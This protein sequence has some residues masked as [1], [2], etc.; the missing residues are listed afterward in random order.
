MKFSRWKLYSVFKKEFNV[1][2][3]ALDMYLPIDPN[4]VNDAGIQIHYLGYYLNGILKK[5][6]TM[7]NTVVLRLLQSGQLA[8][9]KY[10][11]ID[12]KI[13]DFHYFTTFIKFGIGRAS[14]DASQEIR[15]GEI[16][17]QEGVALVHKFDGE[18]PTLF[19]RNFPIFE[20]P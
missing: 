9:S 1:S 10:N 13:D 17:R 14:Y 11:S 18:F 15:S 8:H 20:Y 7:S 16:D 12:D 4:K 2:K 5:P 19:K 6:I 3:A